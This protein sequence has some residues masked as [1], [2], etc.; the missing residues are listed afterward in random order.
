MFDGINFQGKKQLSCLENLGYFYLNRL[1]ISI[2][3]Q[4][5][6]AITESHIAVPRPALMSFMFEGVISAYFAF[7]KTPAISSEAIIYITKAK[8]AKMAI[9]TTRFIA[10]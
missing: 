10:S 4:L 2:I 7:A 5:P 1:T 6:S 9:P 3:T 8:P